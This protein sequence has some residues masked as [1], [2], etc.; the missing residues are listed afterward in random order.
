MRN[1]IYDSVKLPAP[2]A[3]LFDMYLNP[4]RHA[5]IT[6]QP[7]E[8]GSES[9]NKFQAFEGV[10]TGTIL[11]VVRPRLIVQSWRSTLFHEEDPD[12]TLILNFSQRGEE[13][14]IDLV[15]LDSTYLTTTTMMLSSAGRST[16]GHLGESIYRTAK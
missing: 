14:Q 1:V 12:S 7:V 3:D 10:L 5:A 8:I 13:G 2:A 6:G 9:G 4:T 16:T 11:K 15:H